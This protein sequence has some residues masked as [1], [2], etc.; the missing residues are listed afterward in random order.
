MKNEQSQNLTDNIM[1]VVHN[2]Y[3]NTT[4]RSRSFDTRAGIFI[5]FLMASF[6][7]YLQLVDLNYVKEQIAKSLFHFMEAMQLLFFFL[8][9]ALFIS[10]FITLACVLS[11]RQYLTFNTSLFD[12][13][14]IEEYRNEQI[15][16]DDINVQ[17][18]AEFNSIIPHN[19]LVVEKKAK[20]FKTA[21]WISG[22]YVITT[23]IS[24][25]LIIL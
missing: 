25:L 20:R 12:G 13:M 18:I 3:M 8:S 10:A 5:T 19:I 24:V 11:T 9:I 14:N 2:E 23:V 15:G 4:A 17:L 16:Q 7:L 22:A 21:L 1:N 6:P